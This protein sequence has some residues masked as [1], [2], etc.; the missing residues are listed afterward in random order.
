MKYMYLAGSSGLSY[1]KG[2]V[3]TAK[4]EVYKDCTV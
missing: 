3:S 2:A 4:W 1:M